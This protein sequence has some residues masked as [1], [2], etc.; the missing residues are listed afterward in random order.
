M[1]QKTYDI[2]AI[3]ELLIDFTPAGKNEQGNSLF[4]AN[5]G[6]APGN[7]LALASRLGLQTVLLAKVGDDKFGS[8]LEGVL[9]STG[10]DK[11][12]LVRTNAA[13]TT[14]AFVH[15]SDSGDR[16]FSFYRKPGADMLLDREDI[17]AQILKN[18]SIFHFGSVSMTSQPSR[19][20]TLYA[21][22]AAK[23]NGSLISYD[24][25]LRPPL[26]SSLEEAK[27]V[28]ME[29]LVFA[30]ILKVSDEELKFITGIDG[31]LEGSEMLAA[32]YGIPA[33]LVTL[34]SK[35]CFFKYGDLTGIMPAYSVKTIDTTGAG[36]AFLGAFLYKV[37]KRGCILD[38]MT[39][40]EIR[41]MVDFA[42]AAGSLATTAMGAI[43]A[44]PSFEAIEACRSCNP[45][46]QI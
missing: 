8:F 38:N 15:L 7:V 18:A 28:I 40:D 45:A 33:I 6:G 34:G 29:G 30:D 32:E 11:K 20:A 16:S 26:W 37:V 24:P 2:A 13:N 12:G 27:A 5:P 19:G 21:V 3:G 31:L 42:N 10:I 41:S 14:L 9:E 22:E 25:N 44:M 23:R 43:P 35:G 36:D 39:M 17:D 1:L 4:A 46:L